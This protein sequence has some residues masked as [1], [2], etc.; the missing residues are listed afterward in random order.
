MVFEIARITIDPARAEDFE[1]AVAQAEPHFRADP[2]CT[3][4]ALQ[5]V[6][7]EP[8]VYHL[9]VGWTSV[10]A[11]NVDFRSTDN[12]AKWRALAG[13]FFVEPP[14]VVHVETVIGEA[15]VK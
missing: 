6:V 3:G 11:H 9:L 4:F 14:K 10:E 12:F 8:G 15:G 13:P 2:G 7:E 5:R 1:A